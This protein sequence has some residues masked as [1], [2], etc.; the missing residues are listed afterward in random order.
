[1]NKGT[2]LI[3]A[4]GAAIQHLV[5]VALDD[6]DYTMSAAADGTE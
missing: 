2:V 4:A 3:V 1:M 5:Q 6:E